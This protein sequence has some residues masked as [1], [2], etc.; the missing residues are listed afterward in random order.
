M[1]GVFV[2][3]SGLTMQQR[4]R[5]QS[6]FEDQNGLLRVNFYRVPIARSKETP[7]NGGVGDGLRTEA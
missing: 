7:N 1:G 3:F 5:F 2:V 4:T 6:E